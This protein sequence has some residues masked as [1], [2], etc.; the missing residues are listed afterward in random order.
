MQ[1]LNSRADNSTSCHAKG[2][3]SATFP[4]KRCRAE[5]SRT[6]PKKVNK[7][8]PAFASGTSEMRGKE[9]SWGA[10]YPLDGLEG[11]IIRK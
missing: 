8:H 5:K 11:A 7:T 2:F 10:A 1:G 6:A 4:R 9:Q 3:Y